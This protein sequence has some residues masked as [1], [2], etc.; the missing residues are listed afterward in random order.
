MKSQQQEGRHFEQDQTVQGKPSIG[1][2]KVMPDEAPHRFRQATHERQGKMTDT[3][4]RSKICQ[5][6][7]RILSLIGAKQHDQIVLN[8]GLSRKYGLRSRFHGV[9]L[10][11]FWLLATLIIITLIIMVLHMQDPVHSALVLCFWQDCRVAAAFEA[12]PHEAICLLLQACSLHQFGSSAR[13]PR[14]TK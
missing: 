4:W 13:V 14:V 1:K 5:P 10:I 8:V 7:T 12:G 6:S 9:A 11:A 3:F 2:F